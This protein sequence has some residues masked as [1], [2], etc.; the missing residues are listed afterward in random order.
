MLPHPLVAYVARPHVAFCWGVMADMAIK[1]AVVGTYSSGKTTLVNGLLDRYPDLHLLPEHA[2]RVIAAG[3]LDVIRTIETRDFLLVANLL[4]EGES[5]A[6]PYPAISD[7]GLINNLA[8]EALFFDSPPDRAWALAAF[9]HRPY[10]VVFWCDPGDV[11]LVD[12][13]QRI[14]S[15]ETRARLHALVGNVLAGLSIEPVVLQGDPVHRLNVAISNIDACSAP[16]DR[17]TLHE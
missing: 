17:L 15:L 8:H 5:D 7:S 12:D 14:L 2:R 4:D 3:G 9:A 11:A 16:T 10:D 1:I 13:G 6:R